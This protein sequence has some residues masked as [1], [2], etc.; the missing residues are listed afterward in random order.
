MIGSNI[1]TD[2]GSPPKTVQQVDF[3][4]KQIQTEFE[5]NHYS[6]P[7]SPELLPGMYS[8][9]ILAVPKKPGSD[10]LCLCNHQ[11]YGKF[12]LNSMIKRENFAGVMLDGIRELGESLHLYRCQHGNVQ[13]VVFKSDMKA[14]YHQMPIHFLWQIK[15]IITFRDHCHVDHS[16]C[17]G[18]RLH[19][20]Y[21]WHSW[22][23]LHGL[24]FM[25]D[26]LHT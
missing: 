11:S 7:F 4:H 13:L 5:A 22:V 23:S 9:P 3:L 15:Q 17:F 2:S 12:S 25:Y 16:A 6:A 10:K 21:L 19:K 24:L 8:T 14:T 20:S 1:P 26:L 18:N